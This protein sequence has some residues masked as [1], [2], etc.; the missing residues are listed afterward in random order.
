MKKFIMLSVILGGAFI[1]MF[2]PYLAIFQINDAIQTNNM[3]KFMHLI[4]LPAVKNNVSER[5]KQE[6]YA[7]ETEVSNNP[8]IVNTAKQLIIAKSV[9]YVVDILMTP[10]NIKTVFSELP[11]QKSTSQTS[12]DYIYIGLNEFHINYN[13]NNNKHTIVLKRNALFFWKIED[14]IFKLDPSLF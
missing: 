2:S 3:N 4:N 14:I 13:I 9:T 5:F 12:I 11:K 1:F 7:K 6:L 8:A 10:E